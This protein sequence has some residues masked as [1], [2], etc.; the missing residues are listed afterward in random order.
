[1]SGD[2]D[3]TGR[4]MSVGSFLDRAVTGFLLIDESSTVT[5]AN[6][7][8]VRLLD[9]DGD[10]VGTDLKAVD[11]IVG[12]ELAETVEEVARRG[13]IV[14]SET[15]LPEG[16]TVE[17]RA[18]PTSGGVALLVRDASDR[19]A[20]RRRLQRSNRVL[21]T[22]ED[23]VYTLDE[24]FVITSVNEAVTSMTGYDRD[25]LVGSHASMLAG[26]ETLSMAGEIIEQL[27]GDDSDVGMIESSIRTAD[28]DSLPIETHFSS[29][30]FATGRQQRVGVIRDVTD[31]K[32]NEHALRELNRSARL[33][34][35]TEDERAVYQT[36]VDVATSVWP[37][38]TVVAYSLDRSA[39]VL[40]PVAASITD[41]EVC[42][43]GSAV[44]KAF[45]TGDGL[46]EPPDQTGEPADSATGGPAD[47]SPTF[48]R[49]SSPSSLEE[50]EDPEAG[51]TPT[52]HVVERSDGTESTGTRTLYAT[53]G[54]YGLL[55]IELPD[56]E[57]AGNV[58]ESAELL[59]ANA[60]AALDRVDREAELSQH[61]E[62][63]SERT[64]QLQRL[65]GYHDLLRR[66]NGALVEAD[67]LE[68]I[69]TAVC[70]PLLEAESVAF[71]WIGET[72]RT[73][74]ALRPVAS[75][76]DGEGYLDGLPAAEGSGNVPA[77]QSD[78][79]PSHRALGS[80]SPI[81]V[82]DVSDGLRAS[83]WRERALARG[84]GSVLSVPLSHDD[85]KYGVLSVYADERGAFEGEL[86]ELLAELGDTV[87]DAISSVETRRSLQSESVVE[88]RV[89]IDGSNAILS[90][91]AST[92]GEPLHVDGTVRQTDDR[93]LVYFTTEA[94]PTALSETVHAVESVRSLDGDSDSRIEVSIAATTVIDRVTA[95]GGSVDRLI[96]DSDGFDATITLS[97]AVDV[98]T[99][100]ESLADRY[101]SVELLARGDREAAGD[102]VSG[103]MVTEALTD[104]QREAAR[105]AYLGGYFEW[106]RTSTGEDVAAAMG[107]TQ[108][109]F[110]RHLRTA[111]RKLFAA[112]FDSPAGVE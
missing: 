37:S 46:T 91:I 67:T 5:A 33:L 104:R 18:V 24:A 19:V 2:D 32:Q 73:G 14:E 8:G 48:H 62:T 29:V 10:P 105:T 77:G 109:T 71:A 30:E 87:A 107:I 54:E 97:P 79:E 13:R 74:G 76:G 90:R 70:D 101:E 83:P 68:G 88:L 102:D 51:T 23:G 41:P 55:R 49:I 106:P 98:R 26:E 81:Y 58:A 78:G 84:F 22:L 53:L 64:R 69:A 40:E 16:A 44:W 27:R 93:A 60:V 111:E 50:P 99:V 63:L 108:P 94:D 11:P 100:I 39:S 34:L 65:H 92:V 47:Q 12:P 96:A 38:A 61:R 45:S 95:H 35:G 17:V 1:M 56:E 66:I 86:R 57:V 6:E 42:P 20:M 36:T 25:E 4:S 52:G 82:P 28:G 7:S 43:P 110:N 15:M 89:R 59:A 103:S 9:I 85:L 80:G 112:L 21:E 3:G 31:R 72:Y 75:A